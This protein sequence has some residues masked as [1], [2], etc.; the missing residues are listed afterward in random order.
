MIL[1]YSSRNFRDKIETMEY[2][3]LNKNQNREIIVFFNGWGMD[4]SV[5]K[6][7]QFD[8]YDVLMFYDYNTLDTDF[9][10]PTLNFYEKRHLISWSMGVMTATLFNIKYDSATAVNG[11]LKPIDNSFGIPEK[12]YDLTLKGFSEK[13]AERFIKNMF[14]TECPL[15]E[16]NRDFENRKSEL[17]ALKQ[18]KANENFKY[19]RVL[20]SDND[21]IIPT[22]N[23]IAF[24]NKEANI[25]SGHCPFLLFKN[26]EELL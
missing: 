22:K 20:I 17:F 21:K 23:Q 16:V 24:W 19:S 7:L 2:K 6:H 12:I 15:P 18:Y 26:W 13:G 25:K 5:V 3:W 8:N 14:D 9:D 10:F 1:F 11:T 4:G